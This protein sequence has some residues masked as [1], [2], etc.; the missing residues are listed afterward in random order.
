MKRKPVVVVC[1]L[2]FSL[3]VP[4]FGY[5]YLGALYALLFLMG[6]LAGFIAWLLVPTKVPYASIKAPFWATLLAF[7][8]LHKV[9]ENKMKFFEV[10]SAKITGTP[11][12]EVTPLL[13]IGLLILPIGS[14]LLIPYLM[15]KGHDFGYYLA[16]TFFASM[17]LVEL[18]HFFFP[19]FT[20]EPYGYFPGMA[21]AIILA[22]LGWWGMWRLSR[23]GK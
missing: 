22:P 5:A 10:L 9:E 2:L 8:L 11:V 20:D 4:A 3:V 21:S 15:K 12:P 14:W 16:W 1:A 17:G 23:K 19:L 6:Y 7:L 18:A 13:I